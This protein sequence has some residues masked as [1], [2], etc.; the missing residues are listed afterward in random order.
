MI[1]EVACAMLVRDGRLLL[2][3]RSPQR[4]SYP[5]CWDVI[6]GHLEAGETPEQAL[7]REVSEEVGL[8]PTR[9]R[10]VGELP[11]PMPERHGPARLYFF[12]VTQWAGGE[13]TLRGDEHTR[14]RWFTVADA[15]ALPDLASPS[16]HPMF[17]SLAADG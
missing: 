3:R 6:G 4:R 12:A 16:Y 5:D 1:R 15:C 9:F 17:R 10:A 2:G 8:T 7:L 11:E 14:L 13:P